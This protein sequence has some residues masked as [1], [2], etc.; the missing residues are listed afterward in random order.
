MDVDSV[1]NELCSRVIAC[2][3]R[4]HTRLGP[5]LLESIYRDCLLAELLLE[6]LLVETEAPVPV[7]YLGKR[8]RDDLRLDLLVGGILIVEVKSVAAILPVHKA[9]LITY[10]KLANKPAGLLLNFNCVM[11]RDGIRRV[12]RPDI[13]AKKAEARKSHPGRQ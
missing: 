13:Y 2:A 11:M 5:G 1:V 7:E 10:V 9:Q 12:D 8:I 4:V 3:I 6:G